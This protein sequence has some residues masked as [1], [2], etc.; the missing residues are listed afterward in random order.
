MGYNI[1][2]TPEAE[3]TLTSV[4]KFIFNNFGKR[5]ANTFLQQADKIISMISEMPLMYKAAP[6]DETVRI[7]FISKQTSIFYRVK[8]ETVELLFFWDNRQ[9]ALV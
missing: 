1:V 7:G 6:F 8:E 3:D 9:E 5:S 4:H 2:V